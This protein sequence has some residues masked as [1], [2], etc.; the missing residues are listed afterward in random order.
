MTLETPLHLQRVR[1]PR[2]RHHIDLAMASLA[3]DPLLY[4]NSVVKVNEIGEIVHADPL[5]RH[6][7]LVACADRL[8]HGARVP[9]L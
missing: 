7:C 9:D 6:L 1:P 3:S 8:Q 4:M 2:Q 5:K